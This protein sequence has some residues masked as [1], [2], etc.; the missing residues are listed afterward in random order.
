VAYVDG[1]WRAVDTTPARWAE[2]E[3]Q[4]ASFIQPGLDI[5]SNGLFM[6][7]RWWNRQK[8]EDYQNYLYVLGAVLMLILV[9]RISTSK[10][11]IIAAPSSG[12]DDQ[13]AR[14]SSPFTAVIDQLQSE[15]LNR[16]RGEL[17]DPWLRRI[18]QPELL[19]G[20]NIHYK[21]VY[22][23]DSPDENETQALHE[24]VNRW[25]ATR[26]TNDITGT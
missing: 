18:E 25:L 4:S 10:Q 6:F 14:N 5:L 19:P 26:R 24:L 13:P 1:R 22:G 8:L 17:L 2:T 3:A 20:I 11:V 16:S 12:D 7:Q 15:G 23:A 21:F 9:W